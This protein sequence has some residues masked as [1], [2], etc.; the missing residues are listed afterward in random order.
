VPNPTALGH[1]G[2]AAL[3]SIKIDRPPDV[4]GE[5]DAADTLTWVETAGFCHS[6]PLADP[7]H[8]GFGFAAQA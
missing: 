6:S 3:R 2:H 4:I 5:Q 8:P 7:D 1:G